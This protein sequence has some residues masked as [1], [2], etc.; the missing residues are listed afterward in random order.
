MARARSV[1][2]ILAVLLGCLGA[3]LAGAWVGQHRSLDR[4]V[5]QVGPAS[6][7]NVFLKVD[8]PTG[9]YSY[10]CLDEEALCDFTCDELL[11]PLRKALE[12]VPH[13]EDGSL[14]RTDATYAWHLSLGLIDHCQA[15]GVAALLDVYSPSRG[16]EVKGRIAQALAKR[17]RREAVPTL[18]NGIRGEESPWVLELID[19]SLSDL[20][21]LPRYYSQETPSDVPTLG[22]MDLYHSWRERTAQWGGALS[23]EPTQDLPP[24]PTGLEAGARSPGGT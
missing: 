22:W 5:D 4:E 23:A 1:L 10:D 8:N 14:H 17:E 3:F 2:A 21:L 6:V 15:R 20:T 19:A 24:P 7:E 12:Q 13:D 16:K 9:I 11:G 18:V